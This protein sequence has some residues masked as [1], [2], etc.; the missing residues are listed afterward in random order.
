M[1]VL[2]TPKLARKYSTSTS[3]GRTEKGGGFWRLSPFDACR[4]RALACKRRSH[5]HFWQDFHLVG[6]RDRRHA[7][8]HLEHGRE[9]RRGRP[10]QPLFPR[11]KGRPPLGDL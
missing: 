10:R 4:P 7:A 5:E 1:T 3:S 2:S 9:G 8:E 6:R 11:E